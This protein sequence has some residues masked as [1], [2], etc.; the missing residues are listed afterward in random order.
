M[1]TKLKIGRGGRLALALLSLS[2][3]FTPMAACGS[4]SF[5]NRPQG[6]LDVI[7]TIF[8]PFDFAREAGGPFVEVTML[9]PPGAESHT[10]EP[11]PR[12]VVRIAS[13]DLFIY[14]GGPSDTWVDRLLSAAQIDT[15]KTLRMM[16]FVNPVEEA[17]EGLLQDDASGHGGPLHHH[18]DE[19]VWTD[20]MNAL[21]ITKG[22]ADRLAAIDPGHAGDYRAN[23]ERYARELRELDGLFRQVVREGVRKEIIVADRFPLIYFTRAYGLDYLAAFPGCAAETDPKPQTVAAM[24]GKVREDRIPY[25]FHIEF[26]NEKLADLICEE[27]GAEKLLFHTAHNVSWQAID[28]GASYLS[29][30]RENARNLAKGLG[31]P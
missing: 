16:A 4:G 8:P 3:T 19:H 30:M 7:A 21:A 12:E 26:S 25:I 24:I 18:Y 17:E 5:G 15:E 14:N 9:I 27:T 1:G 13:C 10:Y 20:P 28:Q 2:L 6:K 29:I 23:A 31:L 11:S 22:I